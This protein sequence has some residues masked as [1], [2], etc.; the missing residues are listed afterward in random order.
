M[1]QDTGGYRTY[2]YGSK[3]VKTGA[4]PKATSGIVQSA[5]QRNAAQR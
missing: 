3:L 2:S 4:G 1:L 5:T